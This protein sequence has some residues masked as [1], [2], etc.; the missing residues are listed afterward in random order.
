[1]LTWHLE[2]WVGDCGNAVGPPTLR[3][4]QRDEAHAADCQ[5]VGHAH[6]GADQGHESQLR[7]VQVAQRAALWLGQGV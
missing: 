1:M 4:W 6:L 3:G 2:C 7:W 5:G